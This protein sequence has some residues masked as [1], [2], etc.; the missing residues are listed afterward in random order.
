MKKTIF[1]AVTALIAMAAPAQT[2]LSLDEVKSLAVKA[3]MKTR[4]A[5]YAIAEA[6]EQKK[7]A[8]TNYFPT[9]SASSTALKSNHG[10]IKVETALGGQNLN[11]TLLDKMWAAGVT[12]VQPVF[13]GGQIVNGNK[14]A[15]TGVEASQLQENLSRNDV[16]L[17]AENYY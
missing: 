14:L 15:K 17:T 5:A 10:M 2:T 12:A 11:M 7:E 6:R 1:L 3:N 16:E 4:S 13:M 9:V 8:F